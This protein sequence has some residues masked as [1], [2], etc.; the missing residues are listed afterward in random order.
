MQVT[1]AENGRQAVE[2]WRAQRFDLILMD[3]QMPELDGFDATR[4]IRAGEQAAA[5]AGKAG[6]PIIAL[7]ANAFEADRE[8]CLASGMND[9]IAKPFTQGELY[10]TLSRWI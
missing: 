1:L 5:A 2:R 7:T 4:Q 3:C 9:F 8:R 6:I 10:R